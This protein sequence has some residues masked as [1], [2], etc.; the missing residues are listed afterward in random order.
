MKP[1]FINSAKDTK[2]HQEESNI[3]QKIVNIEKKEEK[4]DEYKIIRDYYKINEKVPVVKGDKFYE[5]DYLMKFRNV[6]F[7]NLQWKIC[8]EDKLISDF[9]KGH[10]EQMKFFK[11]DFNAPKQLIKGNVKSCTNY[12]SNPIN[13]SINM[14]NSKA[15]TPRESVSNQ[16]INN[17]TNIVSKEES[18]SRHHTVTTPCPVTSQQKSIGDFARKNIDEDVVIL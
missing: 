15:E 2:P 4:K 12:S 17:N 9:L 18:F 16:I 13:N 7:F 3:E 8:K 14:R 1:V 5:L 6:K 11:D 10:H